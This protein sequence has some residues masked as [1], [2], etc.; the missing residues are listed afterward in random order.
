MVVSLMLVDG[1]GLL[2]LM[3]ADS[4]KHILHTGISAVLLFPKIGG[5]VGQ[6]LWSTLIKTLVASGIMGGAI[7]IALPRLTNWIGTEG[8]IREGLLVATSGGMAIGIFL[9]LAWMLRLEELRWL[10]QKIRN[11]G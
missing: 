2:S 7:Y 6:R 10:M 4:T 11:R 3:I 5:I 1:F 9:I 8:F